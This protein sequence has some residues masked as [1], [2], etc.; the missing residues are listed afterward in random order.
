MTP[1]RRS[2][3]DS[4]CRRLSAPRSLKV[5]VNCKFSNLSQTR[6]PSTEPSVRLSLHSV[7][8]V[9]PSM[10]AAAALT[11]ASVTGRASASRDGL[12][13]SGIS[14]VLAIFIRLDHRGLIADR[15]AGLA[16]RALD[17]G[18]DLFQAD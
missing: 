17:L 2:S 1:R 16:E 3:G 13:W 10:I 4:A 8:I 5:E 11:S 9:A 12:G 14:R 18:C 7:R 6:Q 15:R